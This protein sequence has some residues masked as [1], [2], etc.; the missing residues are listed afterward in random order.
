MVTGRPPFVGDDSVAI[1]GQHLNTPPVAPAWH[2]KDVPPALEALI[3]R[4]LEKDPSSRP[5]SAHEVHGALDA[6][7]LE[8][9]LEPA[10]ADR[11]ASEGPA[12][13]YRHTFL[14]REAEVRQLHAAFDGAMSGEGSL[15]MVV[16]EPGIGKTYLTE[17]LA[18]YVKLRGGTSLVGHCYEEVSLSLPYLA[19][20]EA[21]RSY[22]LAR[23]PEDL[24]EELGSRA[25][26]VARIVSEIRDRLEVA[27][28]DPTDP[29]QDRYRLLQA[30]ASF[31]RNAAAV[32]PIL[33]VL[34]D[35]HDADRGTLDLLKH[36]ARNLS[37]SR[38]MIVGTYR[39]VEVDRT[40]ALSGTLADLSQDLQFR[41]HP[42]PG[43][44]R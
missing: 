44:D 15:M 25:S 26:D 21:M 36:V 22:V 41:A 20:V 9:G 35:L 10:P 34:K 32:Q 1:I 5:R 31:L 33:I 7:D 30:V 19:F 17:Q 39:D 37:G 8:A 42:A 43:P 11:A 40:H 4:L 16:G 18:T 3:M 28:S 29:E 12:P 2:N 14:G 27:P 38:L 13:V 24:K 23:E 6:I